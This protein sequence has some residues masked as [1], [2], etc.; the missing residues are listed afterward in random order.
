MRICFLGAGSTVFAKNVLGD[1]I[2]TPSLGEFE[3]ALHDIDEKRLKESFNV[4]NAVNKAA[5]GKATVTMHL[6]RR[7]ALKG[8][9]FIINA[10][11]VGGYKPC[12]VTDFKIP[13]RYGLWQT[14]GDTLGVGGI[15]RAMRTIPV[16]E[17]FARD[18]E[19]LCPE[20]YFL[21]YTNPMA[22]LTGYLLTYTKVKAVG[23]CHSVQG[24]VPELLKKLRMKDVDASQTNW[25]I[26]GINHQA[27]L[28]KVEDKDGK[29][30]YPEIKRLASG[31][32]PSLYAWV[33]AVRFEM[34][35]TF[36]YYVTES[37]EHNAEYLPW[38]IKK[39]N[40]FL[41]AKYK[42]PI[43]E[44]PRRCRVQIRRWKKTAKKLQSSDSLAHTRS[45]EYGSRIIEA[46]HTGT[47]FSFNG[48][49]LNTDLLI[50]NLP[51][52]SCVE[53]PIVAD[54]DGF[55]PQECRALPEQLAAINRTNINPQLL[56]L[57]ACE[58]KKLE[59]VYMAVALDPHA[60]A[61]LSLDKIKSMCDALYKRHRKGGWLP[62]Y[63]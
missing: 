56:T 8:S 45:N 36:G 15:M 1:C 3:I 2:L 7:E 49:V 43:N 42:V 31:R 53:V 62:E 4:I 12:T 39:F 50:P 51:K 6:D 29:D 5:N 13:R 48:S 57:K 11:Q 35:K 23:L 37:S 58:T 19:E 54:K 52:E 24:C 17:E 63:K 44:Y 46:I 16:L 41:L 55:H 61:V 27:W 30:L 10:I 34:M 14:I 20:A 9:D 21:N 60:G 33:D 28:L 26:F 18:I 40:P 22:M 32:A 38:F 59:D 47:P 25:E